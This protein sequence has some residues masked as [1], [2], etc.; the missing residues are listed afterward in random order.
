VADL[1]RW[2]SLDPLGFI[3]G[4]NLS[5]Y[6]SNSPVTLSDPSG[7]AAATP[8]TVQWCE[9]YVQA[10]LTGN[11]P[12]AMQIGQ[13]CPGAPNYTCDPNT[14]SVT[15]S[16]GTITLGL[17]GADQGATAVNVI[18]EI[19]HYLDHCRHDGSYRT[20]HHMACLEV[21]A[22]SYSGQCDSDK[23]GPGW[24][25]RVG[26]S[27]KDCVRRSALGSHRTNTLF[28]FWPTD[29][30]NSVFDRCYVDEFSIW[31]LKPIPNNPFPLPIVCDYE[32]LNDF[33]YP[34]LP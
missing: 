4:P 17:F 13:D 15:H 2:L 7:L 5:L 1:G 31:T 28:C 32:P 8:A 27:R 20:C 11:T 25:R 3:D 34:G 10:F 22:I 14:T 23:V 19:T 30:I 6:A 12:L 9:A 33:D 26:E 29:D 18:H 16:G 21:R 24:W